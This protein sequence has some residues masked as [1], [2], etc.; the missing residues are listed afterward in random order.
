[1]RTQ[2]LWA[3]VG[4]LVTTGCAADSPVGPSASSTKAPASLDQRVRDAGGS[5]PGDCP[6]NV[7]AY[8]Q[9]EARDGSQLQFGCCANIPAQS[10][11]FT[12]TTCW[13]TS[14]TG[15]FEGAVTATN[16]PLRFV[17]G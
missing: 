14:G 8:F 3:V 5:L 6:G 1:M 2:A 7:P 15:R 16:Y 11:S 13:S 9:L 4:A 10:S 12:M 17:A